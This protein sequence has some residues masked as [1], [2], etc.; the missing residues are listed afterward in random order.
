MNFSNSPILK[1]IYGVTNGTRT[2]DPRNHN[3]KPTLFQTFL[4]SA[5]THTK[6]LN[7]FGKVAISPTL[8][9]RS[10]R[11]DSRCSVTTVSPKGRSA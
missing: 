11:L 10:D 5:K 4:N 2:R 1:T 7:L 3:P 9:H 8:S 6:I